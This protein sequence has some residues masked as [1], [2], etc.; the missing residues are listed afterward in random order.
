MSRINDIGIELGL[1]VKTLRGSNLILG[2]S[3]Y[4]FDIKEMM[5]KII[6]LENK[7][8]AIADYLKVTIEEIKPEKRRFVVKEK[9]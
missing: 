4:N 9:K 7:V 8:N 3:T 5:E 1:L 6:M 2:A